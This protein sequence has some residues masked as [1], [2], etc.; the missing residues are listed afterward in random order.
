MKTMLN[1]SAAAVLG[2][3]LLLPVQ[4]FAAGSGGNGG[5]GGGSSQPGCPQ[6]QVYSQQK[7]MCVNAQSG[8][9]DDKSLTDYAYSL[10]QAGRYQEALAT[11]DLMQDP[12]TAVA[13]NYR[14]YATRKLGR[15]DEGVSYYL[16]AVA[17]DPE[18]TLVR[19]YLGEAY[20]IQGKLDLAKQQLGEIEQRCG[21]TC[22][23]YQDLAEA[24][25]AAI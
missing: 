7:R 13:L 17:L 22:E 1:L 5:G 16:Q 15:V 19:E 21:T 9:I 2:G 18:Y 8:V 4:A 12:N 14:G 23:P 10:A 24:I 6:G 11:L 3:S 20:V 25:D